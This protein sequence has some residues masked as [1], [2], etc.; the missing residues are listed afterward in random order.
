MRTLFIATLLGGI[1]VSAIAEEVRLEV[2][3][4]D[5]QRIVK[6]TPA[7]DVAYKPG[8]DVNGNPVAPADLNGGSQ[9][10]IPDQIYINLSL[11]FKDLLKNYN[12]KLKNAEV[13]VGT[14]EYN[15]A[16]GKLLYNGQELTDPVKNAIANECRKRYQ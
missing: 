6:Y 10:K 16:S 13:Y 11:P 9:I 5:C 3:K 14:V 8:V 7:P 1:S 15:L 12:P 2:S 4:S